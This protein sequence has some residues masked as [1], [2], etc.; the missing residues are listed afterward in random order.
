[1]CVLFYIIRFCFRAFKLPWLCLSTLSHLYGAND[2]FNGT[3]LEKIAIFLFIIGFSVGWIVN[4]EVWKF[5]VFYCIQRNEC[6]LKKQRGRHWQFPTVSLPVWIIWELLDFALLF[7]MPFILSMRSFALSR[8]WS[9]CFLF[10]SFLSLV[11]AVL[12][13]SDT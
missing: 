2:Q 10:F 9:Q 11:H 13:G 12:K 4:M 6:H 3:G 5:A 8:N 7:Q 1:M